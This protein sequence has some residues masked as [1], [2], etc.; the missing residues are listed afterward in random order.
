MDLETETQERKRKMSKGERT[1]KRRE[2]KILC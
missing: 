2:E 1:N